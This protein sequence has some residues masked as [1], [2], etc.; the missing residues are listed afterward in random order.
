[1]RDAANL[2]W[3]LTGV[4]KGHFKDEILDSYD[5]ERRSHIKDMTA[6]T[7]SLGQK[8]MPT[9]RFKAWVR[10]CVML[11][12]WQFSAERRKLNRG[13]MIPKPSIAGSTLVNWS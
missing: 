13:D 1:M 8:I 4:I 9:S 5:P 3:K 6:L 11:T 2:A 12:L 10:D 7:I